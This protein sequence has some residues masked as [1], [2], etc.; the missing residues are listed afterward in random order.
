MAGMG[1]I[2]ATHNAQMGVSRGLVVVL[3]PREV[4]LW[5]AEAV[6]MSLT[7]HKRVIVEDR[8]L[9]WL[10]G[11]ILYGWQGRYRCHSQCTKG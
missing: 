3:A 4:S 7:M 2:D 10:W 8:W 1:G 5:L 9:F 11:K 6:S